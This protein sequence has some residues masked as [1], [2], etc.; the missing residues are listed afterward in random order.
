VKLESVL[1][2]A[3]LILKLSSGD[4][5]RKSLFRC[6]TPVV[7]RS[8]PG[9]G[10][11]IGLP[12]LG[13]DL[14]CRCVCRNWDGPL[15]NPAGG[16]RVGTCTGTTARRTTI[17]WRG[18]GCCRDLSLKGPPTCASQGRPDSFFC[19]FSFQGETNQAHESQRL[20]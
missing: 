20:V 8:A 6:E 5:E 9:Y 2:L 16:T 1:V 12:Q 18:R 4:E 7:K 19:A 15:A 17:V 14:N 13:W 3:P 10:Y 11:R